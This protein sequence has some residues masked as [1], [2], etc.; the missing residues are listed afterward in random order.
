MW[1][2]S[3]KR[4]KVTE[5]KK[6]VTKKTKPDSNSSLLEHQNLVNTCLAIL[7]STGESF[8]GFEMEDQNSGAWG[9]TPI[10]TSSDGDLNMNRAFNTEP[11]CSQAPS[12]EANLYIRRPLG[13][14]PSRPISS[15][16]NVEIPTINL[17]PPSYN[18]P[19]SYSQPSLN[20]SAA[21]FTLP[22]YTAP[23]NLRLPAFPELEESST[24]KLLREMTS[25]MEIGFKNLGSQF[26]RNQTQAMAAA[27][28]S[29]PSVPRNAN[30]SQMSRPNSDE[31]ISRLEQLVTSLAS[32]VN[33][34]SL[35]LDS[36]T[37][38]GSSSNR[39]QNQGSQFP[40]HPLNFPQYGSQVPPNFSNPQ[41]QIPQY[42]NTSRNENVYRSLPHKWRVRYIL[43]IIALFQWSSLLIS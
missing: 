16:H 4:K 8:E 34:L 31:N 32:S 20:Y 41:F 42:S 2:R 18:H 1:L 11:I 9:G 12:E 37:G 13:R 17:P 22:Q 19:P 33:T 23:S 15:V 26:Q 14:S 3:G 7:E 35:R 38:P 36:F 5:N 39:P 24:M 25:K 27:E 29:Q 10:P 40:S 28:I 43:A 30:A 6:K 21:N